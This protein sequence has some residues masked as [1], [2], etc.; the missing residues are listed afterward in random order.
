MTK[1]KQSSY[2]YLI[3]DIHMIYEYFTLKVFILKSIYTQEY[4]YSNIFT[5]KY[6]YLKT[7]GGNL[8][9]IGFEADFVIWKGRVAL[10]A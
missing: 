7:G 5:L 3:D 2:E 4:L 8:D 6:L 10:A 1:I 9:M